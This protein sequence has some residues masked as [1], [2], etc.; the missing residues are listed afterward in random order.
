MASNAT[1]KSTYLSFVIGGEYFAVPVS[2]VLNVL[3]KQPISQVPNAPS[4]LR[5]V[6]NFRGEIIS[7]VRTHRKFGMDEPS[8]DAKYVIITLELDRP[9]EKLILGAIADKVKD[10]ISI[11]EEEIKPVPQVDTEF[12]THHL[13]GIYQKGENFIMLLDVD[14]VFSKEEISKVQEISKLKKKEQK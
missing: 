10:V 7:V 6:I 2:K 14:A 4:Y 1:L 12:N 13:Q 3:E 5:G 11:P 9:D 8:A